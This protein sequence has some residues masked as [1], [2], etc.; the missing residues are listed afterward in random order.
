MAVPAN[1]INVHDII[2]VPGSGDFISRGLRQVHALVREIV[3]SPDDAS[4]V[5]RFVVFEIVENS[6]VRSGMQAVR[7]NN[8]NTGTYGLDPN[9]EWSVIVDPIEVD[10]NPDK[11]YATRTGHLKENDEG[12][13][14]DQIAAMGSQ[15][16]ARYNTIG[17]RGF[18]TQSREANL[19]SSGGFVQK[20]IGTPDEEEAAAN[21]AAARQKRK[22]KLPNEGYVVD[23]PLDFAGKVT[24]L[25]PWIIDALKSKGIESLRL[26]DELAQE[27]ELLTFLVPATANDLP[28]L[29]I[30]AAI[31]HHYLSAETKGLSYVTNPIGKNK[32]VTTLNELFALA[33]NN[34]E[35]FNEFVGLA[36]KTAKSRLELIG[37][38]A[39]A[40]ELYK[41]TAP[42]TEATKND[43][44]KKI[45]K[46]WGGLMNEYLESVRPHI[47]SLEKGGEM[48]APEKIPEKFIDNGKL[49]FTFPKIDLA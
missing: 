4:T 2:R 36:S 1:L 5:G 3:P 38:T 48:I 8:E 14:I 46:A 31:D 26:A 25:D 33:Q 24:D 9:R 47:T 32:P 28:P 39:L 11:Y 13:L 12:A 29:T 49:V 17:P 7:L 35:G 22:R 6:A 41:N 40:W 10:V 45:K 42:S 34:G 37:S 15:P 23:L 19:A 18:P 44:A 27:P 43:I 20:F 16:D 21:R 30:E